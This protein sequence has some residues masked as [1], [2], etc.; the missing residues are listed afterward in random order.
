M[1]LPPTSRTRRFI[2]PALLTFSAI[3]LLVLLVSVSPPVDAE[4]VNLKVPYHGQVETWYCAEASLKMV[5]DYWGE[6]VPQHDIGDVANERPVGGTYATDLVRAARFSNVSASLQYREGG[7]GQLYGYDQRGFGY[8][9]HVNQWSGAEHYEDRYTDLMELVRGGY[10]VILL[11]WLDIEHGITHYRVVKGFDTDT[12]DFLVHDPALGSNLR[13]NMTLLVDDLWTYY[14]RWALVVVPWSVELTVPEASG[15]GDELTVSAQVTYPC[16]PPFDE[17]EKVYTFPTGARATIVVPPPFALAPGEIASRDLNISRGGDADTVNWTLV[18][19]TEEG[20]WTAQV[21]VMAEAS[22]RDYAISYG[23]Y[24]DT[25]GGTGTAT[26]GCD[27]MPPVIEEF[28]VAEGNTIVSESTVALAYKTSDAHTGVARVRLS[29]DDGGT[30]RTIAQSGGMDLVLDLG[31]GDYTLVMRVIDN[32]G[33][34]VTARRSLILDTTPPKVTL[35]QV[36]GG[37]DIVTSPTV[38]VEMRAADAITGIDLMSLRVGDAQ[39]GVWEPYREDLQVTLPSDGTYRVEAQI[40]DGVGNTVTVSDE[41]TVDTTAPYITRFEV[42]G[43]HSYSRN[44]TVE[45]IFSATDGLSEN[46]EWSL[47]EESVGVVRFQEDI[48]VGSGDILTVEWTF[49]GEGSRTLVLV[50]RDDA[51]HTADVSVSLVV[52]SQPPI[53]NIVLNGGDQVTTVADIPVAV[54][55][56]DVTTE[57]FNARIRVNSNEWGPWSDPGAFRRVDMGPGEGIRSVY[58]QVQDL[59]GNMAEASASVMVDTMVPTVAV[60]FT[61]TE[62]GGIVRGDSSIRLDFSEPMDQ[63]TVQ[64]VL[65]DNSSGIVECDVEWTENGTI[66]EVDP[67]G[68]LPRGSHF[69]LQVSGQD[70]VGNPLDFRGVV[71]STPEAEDDD[72]DAVLPGDSGFVLLLMF[73]VIVAVFALAYGVARRRR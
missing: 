12:G 27:G 45:V 26:V 31:D 8:A 64:V 70:M 48:V 16:P 72:W 54:T 71:F 33:N 30:W 18:S 14:Q 59:A 5:F 6:E 61:K 36:A 2:L 22:T 34:R 11:C 35:F 44:P 56:M 50:V 49:G 1:D 67:K 15:P 68:A 42:A 47:H 43:G 17:V 9:A 73:L 41:V 23:W 63:D 55:A 58:V 7:G 20:F 52:D 51:G 57:V 24:D 66:L 25:V 13:F 39:W 28:T 46:M 60:A 32:V 65:M 29:I 37:Q 10:P 53:V 69:V 4:V 19:P 21:S 38:Q 40:R 3:A 62:P